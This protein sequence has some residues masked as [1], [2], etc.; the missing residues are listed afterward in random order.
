[1]IRISDHAL[2]R[3]LERSG[4]VDTDAFRALL[5]VSLE[6]GRRAAERAGLSEFSIVADGLKYVVRDGTLITVLDG[7]M[8]TMDPRPGPAR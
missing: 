2:L 7:D 4:A 6:R 1:M 3:F 5:S 8:V